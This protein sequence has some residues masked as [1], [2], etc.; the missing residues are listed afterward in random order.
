MP[1][2]SF[3][4][5]NGVNGDATADA[6]DGSFSVDDIGAQTPSGTPQTFSFDV[7]DLK[8]SAAVSSDIVLSDIVSNDSASSAIASSAGLSAVSAAV[9]VPASSPLQYYLKID[10][11]KGDST[12]SGFEGWFSVD[13]YDIGVQ[14]TASFSTGAGGGAG[15]AVFSPLTVDIHS[16]TGLAS[17][18][19]DVAK[20]EHIKSVELVGAQTI[21][22][23]SIKV[24]DVTL[25]DAPVSSFENDPGPN[26]VETSL[27]FNYRQIKLTDQPA[28]KH[29]IIGNP[30]T[31]AFDLSEN[32]IDA[33]V[34]SDFA[35]QINQMAMGLASFM[36]SSQLGASSSQDL[37][38]T[39]STQQDNHLPTVAAPHA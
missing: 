16:L 37:V 24:Y 4:K 15:K 17:L 11:V 10:G 18:F 32:R 2:R 26:G 21:K 34:S 23:Q 33:A 9:L 39:Q 29:A 35:S 7:K 36:A 8:T 28:T 5:I 31:F 3:L 19:S 14:N 12:V 22:D 27:S 25:S 1:L 20:G 13:G 38:S 6:F 30:E